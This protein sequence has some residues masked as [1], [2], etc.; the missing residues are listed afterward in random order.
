MII[1]NISVKEIKFASTVK[2]QIDKA[3]KKLFIESPCCDRFFKT[4]P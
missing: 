1:E 2:N 3:K 4:I